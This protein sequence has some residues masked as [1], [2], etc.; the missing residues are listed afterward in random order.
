MDSAKPQL[1]WRVNQYAQSG[2]RPS[3]WW[4]LEVTFTFP[5]LTQIE[6]AVM[7]MDPQLLFSVCCVQC[8]AYCLFRF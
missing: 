6:A 5:P 3:Q 2:Q 4:L 7:L 8:L 1:P